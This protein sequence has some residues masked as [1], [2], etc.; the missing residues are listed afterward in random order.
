MD[1][2]E[3]SR[4]SLF[5]MFFCLLLAFLAGV[6]AERQGFLEF[7]RNHPR[8]IWRLT[9]QH[10]QLVSIAGGMAIAVGV[11]IG[12]L[13]TR[14][15]M[16]RYREILLNILGICQTVPSLAVI[17][18]AMTYLGIGKKTAIFALII[19]G[20]LPIIRNTVAGLSGVAP[21][22]LDAGRGMGMKPVQLLLRVELPNA[23]YI[24]LTGIRTSIVIMVGTAAL[25]FLIGGGGLGDLIFTGIMMVDPAYMLAGAVPTAALAVVLN[26]FFGVLEKWM[27]S[28]GLVY[29]GA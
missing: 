23:S 19:Y 9:L 16:R 28:P 4:A 26:W 29:D 18:M 5:W 17:A 14:G 7:V 20:L 1:A 22:I 27:I 15:F 10:L 21:V 13:L 12:I 3:H 25:S 24:I 6:F 11:P 2:K 8:D